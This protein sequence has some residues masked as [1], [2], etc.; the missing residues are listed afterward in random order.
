MGLEEFGLQEFVDGGFF[1][2]DLYVDIGQK[3]YKDIG[4]K[5]FWTIGVLMTLFNKPAR[6]ADN[7]VRQVLRIL[8]QQIFCKYSIMQ[9]FLKTFLWVNF[10]GSFWVIVKLC[11]ERHSLCRK[12]TVIG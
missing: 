12:N 6:D 10:H 5:R 11:H 4:Y 3:T 9:W 8:W 1:N 7:K 2:G